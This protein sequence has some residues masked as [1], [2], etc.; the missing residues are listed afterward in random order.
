MVRFIIDV[1][2]A[3]GLFAS[4]WLGVKQDSGA[5]AT[6]GIGAA[7]P[8]SVAEQHP[9]VPPAEVGGIVIHN[10]GHRVADAR[11]DFLTL[12]TPPVPVGS[13]RTNADGAFSGKPT[14]ELPIRL[15]VSAVGFL[16]T[17]VVVSTTSRPIQIE[18]AP[19]TFAF[20]YVLDSEGCPIVGAD[21]T[22]SIFLFGKSW[23][24]TGKADEFGA[25]RVAEPVD[26][27]VFGVERTAWA[28]LHILARAPGF[29]DHVVRSNFEPMRRSVTITMTQGVELRGTVRAKNGGP[30][31]S[32]DVRF[33]AFARHRIAKD[34]EHERFVENPTMVREIASA[35][36]DDKG[37]FVLKNIPESGTFH[38]TGGDVTS[39]ERKL[40]GV[41]FARSDGCAKIARPV[42]DDELGAPI[43]IE[44]GSPAGSI[45]GTVVD[46]EGRPI[47]GA[48]ILVRLEAVSLGRR[49]IDFDAPKAVTDSDGRFL[50][51]GV[52]RGEDL[53]IIVTD[54]RS[55]LTTTRRFDAGST[56]LVKADGIG[57]IYDWGNVT[58]SDRAWSKITCRDRDGRPIAHASVVSKNL[59][60]G[61]FAD[62]LSDAA[63]KLAIWSR[64]SDAPKGPFATKI[65][66][67]GYLSKSVTLSGGDV[68]VVL[69]RAVVVKGRVRGFHAS[70]C[71][72]FLFR[73]DI[74]IDDLGATASFERLTEASLQHVE[75]D[76]EG[77]FRMS[78]PDVDGAILLAKP[79]I[80]APIGI[81]TIRAPFNAVEIR[82]PP[83]S[84]RADIEL[85]VKDADGH[86]IADATA[87]S[88]ADFMIR[89][90][91]N[92]AAGLMI[93]LATGRRHR[94]KV[95]ARGF[96]ST[97]KTF[98]VDDDDRG[99]SIEVVLEP[100][101][102][103]RGSIR[104]ATVTSIPWIQLTS[105][106]NGMK[107]FAKVAADGTFVIEG[108]ADGEWI[109]SERDTRGRRQFPTSLSPYL[110][111]VA[112]D[113]TPIVEF[114]PAVG[115]ILVFSSP[116]A[117][118]PIDAKDLVASV[119][120]TFEGHPSP[121]RLYLGSRYVLPVGTVPLEI[122]R[123]D[124][125]LE[126]REVKITDGAVTIVDL[127]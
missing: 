36:T 89:A 87:E 55:G 58:I 102:T 124:G 10:G 34:L 116:P 24:S 43:E 33:V 63:G 83:R 51:S 120:V 118:R 111:S 119:T 114:T 98:S 52:G 45:R 95:G 84:G 65:V 35:A 104:T 91:P 23:E 77:T 32:A 103:L 110:V 112:Q 29:A 126:V 72:V 79:T 74:P 86:P 22:V 57:E 71:H 93:E 44:I 69:D 76:D 68:E 39:G 40:I 8:T 60:A 121:L 20:G 94:V 122:R 90:R 48:E 73:H 14:S 92:A 97:T 26:R 107:R 96:R 1:I 31:P 19:E 115:G 27:L 46:S 12:D 88:V 109:A 6:F 21:V 85:K 117:S 99:P 66:A 127:H 75:T 105:V 30:S 47:G 81:A 2:G 64:G 13:V 4:A 101:A 5:S 50:L 28:D 15:V 54:P 42:F 61:L 11:I 108:L 100:S 37:R 125:R 53:H 25:F 9:D 106:A 62:S 67:P 59:P 16:P 7:G 17:T 80:D 38:G 56:P 41:L 3:L 123:N 18:L 70:N 78:L 49:P 82:L 113:A